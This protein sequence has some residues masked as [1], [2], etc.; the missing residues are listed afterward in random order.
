MPKASTRTQQFLDSLTSEALIDRLNLALDGASLGIWDWDLRDNSVQFDR[1]W[2]EMLGLAH[3]ATPMELST[4]EE[5]VHPDDLESCY[6]DI[7][8]YLAGE[9]PHYENIHRMQHA[10]GRWVY[11]LDRGRASGWDENGKPIR[12]TGTHFDCTLTEE[13]KRVL[14]HQRER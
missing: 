11:I 10:D 12:F 7:K 4:W 8:A 14:E 13:A 6:V 1:R 5:R 3:E 2:C 9:A